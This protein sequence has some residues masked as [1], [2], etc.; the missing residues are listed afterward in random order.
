MNPGSAGACPICGR[1][2]AQREHNDAFPFCS[3][4]C[5][6]VDLGRWL[7]GSYRVAGPLAIDADARPAPQE[8]PS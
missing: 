7:D 6:L 1:A 5:R 2:R 4:G 8:E 3:P